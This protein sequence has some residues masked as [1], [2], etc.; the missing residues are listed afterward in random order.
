[1]LSPKKEGAEEGTGDIDGDGSSNPIG[2]SIIDEDNKEPMTAQ[3]VEYVR[4]H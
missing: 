2:H 3:Q 1:M 4:Q